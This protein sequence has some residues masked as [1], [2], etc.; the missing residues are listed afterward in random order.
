ML[1]NAY[2]ADRVQRRMRD[3]GEA[4]TLRRISLLTGPQ[5]FKNPPDLSAGAM[6]TAASLTGGQTYVRVAVPSAIG[7]LIP[8]DILTARWST[9]GP[10]HTATMTVMTMPANV[11]TDGDGIPLVDGS[12]HPVFGTPPVYHADSLA[13]DGA[14]PVVPVTAPVLGSGGILVLAD[15]VGAAVV[16]TFLTDATVYG[17]PLTYRQMTELGW[18]EVDGVGLALAAKGIDPP[19]AVNDVILIGASDGIRKLSI[20]QVSRVFSNGTNFMFPVQAR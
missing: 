10:A 3:R 5:P 14:F 6:V 12:G 7:R 18:I 17:N 11:M 20:T 8:G 1:R 15:I 16:F 19:P 13:W 4:M 9:P 2:V